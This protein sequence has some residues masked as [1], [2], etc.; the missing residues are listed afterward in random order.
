M[1]DS[2]ITTTASVFGIRRNSLTVWPPKQKAI[3]ISGGLT[4]TPPP[5]HQ[6]HSPPHYY[7]PTRGRRATA[8]SRSATVL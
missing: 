6:R 8:N 5:S 2:I 4:V 1:K 7:A 3:I